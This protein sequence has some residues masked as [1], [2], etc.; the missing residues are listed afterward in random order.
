[1]GKKLK[2]RLFSSLMA[3]AMVLSLAPAAFAM[4]TDAGNKTITVDFA[5]DG[6]DGIQTAIDSISTQSDSTGWTIKVGAG[7]YNRFSISQ[8]FEDLTVVGIDKESVI[9]KTLT[10]EVSDGT[11]DSGGIN[12]FGKNTTLRNMTITA[13]NVEQPSF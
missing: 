2:S 13:G 3:L 1:M 9:V 8:D 12:A 4:E 10:E 11:R 5:T 6:A 7:T